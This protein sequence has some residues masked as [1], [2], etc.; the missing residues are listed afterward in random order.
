MTPTPADDPALKEIWKKLDETFQTQGR[1]RYGARKEIAVLYRTS[2]RTVYRWLNA[3]PTELLNSLTGE[4]TYS[5]RKNPY[6]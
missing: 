2:V 5:L 1:T 6:R 3:E 4:T